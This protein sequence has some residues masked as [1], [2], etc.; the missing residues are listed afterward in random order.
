MATNDLTTL[1]GIGAATAA[2]LAEHGIGSVEALAASSIEQITAVPGFGPVRAAAIRQA[3]AATP[4]APAPA[5]AE[6]RDEP[7]AKKAK[8]KGKKGKKAKK[9]KKGKK[10]KKG[11]KKGKK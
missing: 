2:K 10:A 3:A 4:A 8:K 7:K 6:E 11:K 9:G 5:P 1:S